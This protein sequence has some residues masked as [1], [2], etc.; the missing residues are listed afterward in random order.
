MHQD[1]LL[2]DI[3]FFMIERICDELLIQVSCQQLSVLAQIYRKGPSLKLLFLKSSL[4]CSLHDV[5]SGVSE[6]RQLD[7]TGCGKARNGK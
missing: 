1:A 2:D 7:R 4:P 6:S 5:V 3:Q